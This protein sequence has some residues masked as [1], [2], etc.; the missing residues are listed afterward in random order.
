MYKIVPIKS[1]RGQPEQEDRSLPYPTECH[2][3]PMHMPHRTGDGTLTMVELREALRDVTVRVT[4][5]TMLDVARYFQAPTGELYHTRAHHRRQ[6]D[7]KG[8]EN[9]DDVRISYVLLLDAVFGRREIRPATRGGQSEAGERP[10]S[11]GTP[12]EDFAELARNRRCGTANDGEDDSNDDQRFVDLHRIRAARVAVLD[13]TDSLD[14]PALFVAAA[15][16]AVSAAKVLLRH[17]AT[18]SFV[19]EGTGLTAFS[20]ASS[21]VMRRVLAAAARRSLDQAVSRRENNH[22]TRSAWTERPSET[23]RELQQGVSAVVDNRVR[24]RERHRMEA[25]MY[26]VA[27]AETNSPI[28]GELRVDMKTGLHVAASAGLSEA[29]K[30][31]VKQETSERN[32]DRRESG[33]L[34][35]SG[36]T[37]RVR[38]AW[39]SSWRS[40]TALQEPLRDIVASE[41]HTDMFHQNDDGLLSLKTDTSGWSPLHACCAESS[42]RHTCCA[43][44]LLGSQSDPNL[45]TITGKTPL[46]VA[47]SAPHTTG[48]QGGVSYD[49]LRSN[50][51]YF[52]LVSEL[53]AAMV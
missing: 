21:S 48:S 46:H 11:E 26:T 41:Y 33:R 31:L 20:V 38:P 47:A 19:V 40:T 10:E 25:L 42:T 52:L 53:T 7:I 12:M 22:E 44:T 9:E 35:V 29:V 34:G 17:G 50:P 27:E 32:C 39:A 30:Q 6:R 15:A 49:T 45:R 24:D 5:Q 23:T 2:V 13:T 37:R 4:Q 51:A 3:P 28:G 14:R 1:S 16:G 18:P 8:R 36:G 43:L